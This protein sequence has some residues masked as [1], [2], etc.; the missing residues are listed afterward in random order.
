VI[1]FYIWLLEVFAFSSLLFVAISA[2]FNNKI[3]DLRKI[4]SICNPKKMILASKISNLGMLIA[5]SPLFSVGKQLI[6]VSYGF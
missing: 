1:A 2:I 6:F 4:K 5:F 3:Y